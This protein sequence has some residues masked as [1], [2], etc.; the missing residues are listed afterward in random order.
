MEAKDTAMNLSQIVR[1]L[2]NLIE[3]PTIVKSPELALVQAQAEIS[4]KAGIKEVVEWIIENAAFPMSNLSYVERQATPLDVY[5]EFGDWQAK[6]R[7]WGI[8]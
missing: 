8:G 2:D 4:F 1:V 3:S 5:I 6:L 7:D